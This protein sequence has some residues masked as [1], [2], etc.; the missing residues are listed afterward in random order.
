MRRSHKILLAALIASCF[1]S[2]QPVIRLKARM[3]FAESRQHLR[4]KL[5]MR[6]DAHQILQFDGAV[7]PEI[8]NSLTAAGMRI[9]AD[10]P[11]NALLVNIGS[12]GAANID[13]ESL[14]ARFVT[15]LEPQDKVSQQ[16]DLTQADAHESFFLIEFHSDIDINTARAMILNLAA[17]ASGIELFENPDLG[18]SRLMIR[19]TLGHSSQAVWNLAGLDEVAYIFPP[20]EDLVNRRIAIACA[21]AVTTNGSAGQYIATYGDGWDGPGRNAVALNYVFGVMTSRMGPEAAQ[22]EFRRA[23]AEWSKVAKIT[24]Q[25]GTNGSAPKTM[26]FFFASGAHGDSYAFDGAGRVLAHTFYPSN[27]NPEPIAGDMHLDAD[28]NWNVGANIDLF[29]VVLHEMGHGLGL[30]HSDN[31]NDVMYP[32]YKMVS[33][34]ADG[35]KTAILSLYAAADGTA[36]S[37]PTTPTTPAAPTTPATPATPLTLIV[38]ALPATTTLASISLSGTIAGNGTLSVAWS[39]AT[40]AMG[41]A[42]IAGKNWAIPSIAL[43]IGSNTITLTG[44]DNTAQVTRVITVTRESAPTSTPSD[45]TAPTVT[46]VSPRTSATTASATVTFTGTASDNVGVTKITWSTNTGQSGIATGTTQWSAN[47]PLFTGQNMV[48]I[49]AYDAAGNSSW[50]SLLITRR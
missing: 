7:T 47:I 39:T 8:V 41:L 25:P 38:N 26:N 2:A 49:R 20:S 4:N 12:A 37:T 48:T 32:Y 30:G 50:R 46:I 33:T 43:A 45:T 13:L 3:R 34:L 36:T 28:E 29:S 6:S 24:F 19:T 40:G 21:G 15:E 5:D 31:P 23:M 16:I 17:A 27:P 1:V 44:V 18:A 35:D 42:Q 10:V 22:A 9:L 11:E 14:G